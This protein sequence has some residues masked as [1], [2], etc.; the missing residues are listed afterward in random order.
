M[1]FNVNGIL[2]IY[3]DFSYAIKNS[4]YNIASLCKKVAV[5]IK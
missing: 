2:L 1:C 3:G 5:L 4:P